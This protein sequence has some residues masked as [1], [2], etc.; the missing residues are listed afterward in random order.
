MAP[1]EQINKVL[2]DVTNAPIGTYEY[3]FAPDNRK[4]WGIQFIV[5]GTISIDVMA[6]T[7]PDKDDS[8]KYESVLAEIYGISAITTDEYLHAPA[9]EFSGASWIKIKVVC[10]TGA[11]DYWIGIKGV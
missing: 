9:G 1:K 5:D 2:A 6:T 7:S 8:T 10:S 4:S 11:E 3:I